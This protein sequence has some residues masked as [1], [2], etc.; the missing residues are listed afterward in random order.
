MTSA[1]TTRTSKTGD[2]LSPDFMRQLDKLDVMSRKMLRGSQQGERRTKKKGQSVEFADYRSYVVGDD[3][4]F[5]DWNLYARL[6]K[7][8][9]RLF[10]EEEDL[11]VSLV[12]DVTGSM[13][14]GEP[15]KLDYAKKLCAALGYISLTHYT[16]TGIYTMADGVLESTRG[17][18]GR[19]PIPQMLEFLNRQRALATEANRPG[20]MTSTFKTLAIA[21][22]RPG[23]VIVVSDFWDKGD[24]S[25]AFRFLAGD[26][27]DV[28]L[29]QLLSPQ[30]VDPVKGKVLGDLRLTDLEDGDVAEVSVSYYKQTSTFFLS[31]YDVF[32]AALNAR[33]S[34]R[35]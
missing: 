35:F 32:D 4:R 18:R 14:Y 31:E 25:D 24:V 13:D 15:N 23:V 19:R 33:F 29:I 26:K 2:L 5:V 22:Q 8:F 11:S 7:L 9:I 16:R 30:E 3:L 6:D 27:R 20:D 21:N 12:L 28:Y 10:M 34:R 17:M 1:S